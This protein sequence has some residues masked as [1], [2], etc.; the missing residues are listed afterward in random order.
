MSNADPASLNRPGRHNNYKKLWVLV[1]CTIAFSVVL[2]LFAADNKHGWL[3][4]ATTI[5]WT[6]SAI[7]IWFML[8]GPLFTKA[9]QKLLQKKQSR[10]SDEVL[11]T[12]SF[13]PVLRRLTSL[14]W[15]QSR[16]FRGFKR[17]HFFLGSLIHATLTYTES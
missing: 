5:S 10:Y 12:L 3:A 1:I 13:L 17:W 4:V 2:F 7:L 6:L 14:A 8:I 9:I 16:S 11:K 15:Q